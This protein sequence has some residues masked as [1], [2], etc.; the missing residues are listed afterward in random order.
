MS[1]TVK[2]WQEAV[3]LP[4][5]LTGKQDTHPMFLAHR[6]Y[7]G[8][9]GAV[10]PYGVTDTLTGEKV[11]KTYQALYLE[12]DYIKIML[13]PELGGRVHRA[14]DKV[15]QRDFVYYNEVVKPAL[16]GL[17]GPWISG[18]IE[19]NWPQHHRPTTFMP[20][21]FTIAEQENG[22]KT[23][24][25]GE[26]EPMRGLQVMTGFTVY[27]DKALL[28]ISAKIYNGNPTPRHFLWWAN[29][30]VTGGDGHQSVFPP[31]VT[32]VFDHGKR[33]VSSFPIAT[34]TY[35]KV[36][37]SAGTDISRYKNIP[38]PTSYMADKSD[39]DFVGAYDHD[40]QGGLLH[41]ADHHVSPGKKQWTW[42]NCD[43]GRAW[44][45]NLTDNNGPYIELMTGVFTDN[46][47]D[48]TWLDAYEEKCFVQNFL[49]YSGLGMVQN[50]SEQAVVKLE[51]HGDTLKWGV[52]AV[53]PLQ[54]ARLEI[55]GEK[56][57]E[58]LLEDAINLQPGEVIQGELRGE[59]PARLRLRLLDKQGAE[60]LT[61]QEHQAEEMPLPSPATAPLPAAEVTSAD[62]AWFIG[63]H[64]EQYNHASQ[65]AENYYRRGVALDPLNYRCNLALATLEYNR[66]NFSQAVT[67]ADAAL[68][69]AHRLN[70]NPQCGL[71]S[72]IRASA[73]AQ[74]D[75]FDAAFDGYYR[76][77]W[78][79]N[80]KPGGYFGLA[81]IATRRQQFT[82]AL[83]FCEQGLATQANHYGLI[84]LK[85]LLLCLSGQDARPFID[86]H[87]QQYPLHYLLHF[88]RYHLAPDTGAATE[89]HRV[90]GRRGENAM[91]IAMQLKECGQD[92]LARE[93]LRVLD[94][95]E[96]LPLYLRASLEDEGREALC[97]AARRV[98]PDRVRFP[99]WL[100]EVRLLCAFPDDAFAL[101]LL[102]SF[103]YSKGNTSAAVTCWQRCLTLEP[104]FADAW[105][106]LGIYAWNHQ[107][108]AAEARRCFEEACRL[109]P[110]D[111]RLLFESDLL[112]RLAGVPPQIRLA[113]LEKLLPVA[114][115]RDD[116]TAELLGLYNLSGQLQPAK[117]LLADRQFHPWEGGEGRITG[118]YL[119]NKQLLAFEA[120][121]AGNAVAAQ[122]LLLSALEYPHNLSEGR[123]VGQTDND[124]CFW[125]GVCAQK[126]Q[127][128]KQA[129]AWFERAAAGDKGM[130][131]RRYYNDQPVDYL[132]YQGM[133]LRKLNDP[134]QS[135]QVFTQMLEWAAS[136]ETQPVT[137]DFFAVSLPDLVVLT[138]DRQKD[139]RIHCLLVKALALRGLNDDGSDD[140]LQQI[141]ALDPSCAKAHL[142]SQLPDC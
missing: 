119:I 133:A 61:Y 41:I 2:V 67:L 120:L 44:D 65:G 138:G 99:Q 94:S 3:D 10:Y 14:W 131:E 54:A 51:R 108:D 130:G 137:D 49:P 64:L 39:Y 76:A 36:D 19:F 82:Q 55:A 28:E 109:Q 50:A 23:V 40:Q 33:D 83:N 77:V 15:K 85:A 113:R 45:R 124:I 59:F 62:E 58:L 79:G 142:F 68:S 43:F 20:L 110:Q 46:Q 102:A 98:F 34:G 140:V 26:V 89:L 9:S 101:H 66:A 70:K 11:M 38:V 35:Y 52:Y 69:R 12:N 91:N 123:L 118:Q 125:L 127:Q 63:Q 21:D 112:N 141:F 57:S 86:T 30:A 47:P 128:H 139:H 6:V 18:G 31:D 22:A 71:A 37:Y 75:D 16:V 95:Q 74:T 80:A 114:T 134:A 27:P 25:M 17:L 93:A 103:H 122:A 1:G 32:A 135:R 42:G 96:T 111:A 81:Q 13:L 4:T 126:L 78:S 132:F 60:L 115:Q 136:A 97:Q 72:L 92:L 8:S 116:L 117:A 90:T 5:W 56:D 48:F 129:Q 29:P 24:W 7:Q 106:G 88:L 73:L 107:H 53:S 87:L 105:R 121:N 104:D 100:A 84:G